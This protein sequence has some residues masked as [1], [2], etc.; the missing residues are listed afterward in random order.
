MI[1]FDSNDKE[2]RRSLF[3]TNEDSINRQCCRGKYEFRLG[4]GEL[5]G[6]LSMAAPF[7][8][9]A[10]CYALSLAWDALTGTALDVIKPLL[11]LS[12]FLL[13]SSPFIGIALGW[14]AI[15]RK[16]WIT[17]GLGILT[18][19]AVILYL[20]LISSFI[21]VGLHKSIEGLIQM[22]GII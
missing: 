4:K 15:Q 6:L 22:F 11:E 1:P 21:G 10:I 20:F 5:M 13:L 2:R 9:I 16:S 3:G 18:N 12:G 14:A 8:A 19:L 17:G 7:L